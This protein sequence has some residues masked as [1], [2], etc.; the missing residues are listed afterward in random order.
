MAYKRILVTLDGS[1]LAELALQHT[2]EVAAPG[3]QIHILS[4]M[5]EDRASEI[6]ALASAMGQPVALTSDIWPPLRPS[7]DSRTFHAREDY[8]L[9]V[10]DWLQQVG[11]E[12][13][14]E[15]RPGNIVDTIV[16]VARD[17]FDVVIMATHGRTGIS[18]V[19]MGSVAE[20][21][22]HRAP[23]PVLIV[24]AAWSREQGQCS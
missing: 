18:R 1:K 14:V 6:A 8:L 3:A 22:L 21:V 7:T 13:T 23:C 17:G 16:C 2:L 11:M 5:A 12:V 19:T 20:G 9:Q 24:P 15:V 4:V 10:S